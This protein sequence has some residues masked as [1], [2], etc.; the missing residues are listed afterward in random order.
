MILTTVHI[1]IKKLS[2]EAGQ[3]SKIK[4]GEC[5]NFLLASVQNFSWL[6]F[7]ILGWR[8]KLASVQR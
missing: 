7:K 8:K 2:N 4:A 3:C 1:T 6:V 5:S